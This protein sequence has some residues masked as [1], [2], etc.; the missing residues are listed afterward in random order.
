MAH[1]FNIN[2]YGA[3]L[4]VSP[5]IWNNSK[6]FYW[7]IL[8]R[9]THW[10][11][12]P[13]ISSSNIYFLEICSFCRT[14]RLMVSSGS[15]ST[16]MIFDFSFCCNCWIQ[17]LTHH[18]LTRNLLFSTQLV[19]QVLITLLPCACHWYGTDMTMSWEK[20]KYDKLILVY[21]VACYLI[22]L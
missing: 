14:Q 5:N 8:I 19:T 13:C 1:Q 4:S 10:S 21:S 11:I 9:V 15:G 6:L 22:R 16:K 2:F 18:T 3:T 12:W 17:Y 7:L 20:W